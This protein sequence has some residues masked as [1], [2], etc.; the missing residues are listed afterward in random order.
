M[1]IWVKY[2][3]GIE[4]SYFISGTKYKQQSNDFNDAL[5]LGMDG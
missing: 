3:E 4:R 5:K 2:S 1:P